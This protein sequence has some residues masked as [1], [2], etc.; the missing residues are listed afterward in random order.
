MGVEP[1]LGQSSANYH[2][3]ALYCIHNMA[4]ADDSFNFEEWAT[5]YKLSRKITAALRKEEFEDL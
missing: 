4:E 3:Q 1:L 5:Q 2:G